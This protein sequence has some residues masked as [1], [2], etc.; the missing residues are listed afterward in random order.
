[1]SAEVFVLIIL[2]L[3]LFATLPRWP[4]SLTWGYTPSGLVLII[5]GVLVVWILANQRDTGD[6][7]Q[8]ARDAVQDLGQ[9]VKKDVR[10]ISERMRNVIENTTSQ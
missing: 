7:G 8:D 3:V 5:C 6:L 10:N 4:Y 9:D 1:M 2:V